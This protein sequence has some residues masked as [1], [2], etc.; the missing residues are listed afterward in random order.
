ML[1]PDAISLMLP[2]AIL[3]RYFAD[4]YPMLTPCYFTDAYPISLPM[5]FRSTC[6]DHAIDVHAWMGII[7]YASLDILHS[8]RCALHQT[9]SPLKRL[10]P[11]ILVDAEDALFGLLLRERWAAF[12]LFW[13]RNGLPF[14]RNGLLWNEMCCL[15]TAM[16]SF[17][18]EMGCLDGCTW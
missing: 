10:F 16:A 1:L 2:H 17:W 13:E 4:T 3:R 9:K 15:W 6:L 5:L 11:H 18:N 14:T 8:S 7:M 12:E